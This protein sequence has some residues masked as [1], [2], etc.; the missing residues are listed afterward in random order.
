M[1]ARRIANSSINWTAFAERIPESQRPQFLAF[2][3]KSDGYLRRVN[4]NPAEPPKLDFSA[5]KG[6]VAIPGLVETF[7]KQYEA[8]KIPYPTENLTPKIEGQ[9]TEMAAKIKA[10]VAESND[11][12]KNYHAQ[13]AEFDKI[14]PYEEMTMQ[15]FAEYHPELV[16]D[17]VNNPTLW[18]HVA[19]AQIGYKE[20]GAVA[21]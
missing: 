20:E 8:L 11:R 4:A 15:E 14:I 3:A 21:H 12:I 1:A 13:V 9:K 19:E 10:F 16:V 5:Y 17:T 2:K 6:K 7:Q 18:P